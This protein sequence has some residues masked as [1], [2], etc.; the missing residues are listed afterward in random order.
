MNRGRGGLTPVQR[1]SLA[2]EVETARQFLAHGVVLLRGS[3]S[4]DQTLDVLLLV[5]HMGAERLLKVLYGLTELE[6]GR[7]WPDMQRVI[8][9]RVVKAD[10][11]V[12]DHLHNWVASTPGNTY[13]NGLLA[14]VDADPI[15]PAILAALDDY[16][17]GGRF[18][19]LD[20]LSQSPQE[21]DRPDAVWDQALTAA[22]ES[23]PAVAARFWDNVHN[24]PDRD[25]MRELHDLASTS[26]VRWWSMLAR[27]G[28]CGAF[29]D[30]GKQLA[31]AYGPTMAI[32]TV[33][34]I[35]S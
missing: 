29:G 3:P 5:W 9:H 13:V 8:G 7:S 12:R 22:R 35:D 23:D 14:M 4:V 16:G 15:L 18:F 31:A 17:S 34:L 26:I 24:H 2:V 33:E 10:K 30:L 25:H 20:Q 6:Q 1:V 28:Q 21:R 11:L 19:W 27:T 32:P